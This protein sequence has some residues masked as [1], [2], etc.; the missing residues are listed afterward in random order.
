MLNEAIKANEGCRDGP[1]SCTG[2]SRV[3][4]A[5]RIKALQGGAKCLELHGTCF[6]TTL[7]AFSSANVRTRSGSLTARN[8]DPTCNGVHNHAVWRDP[9]NFGGGNV[10]LVF[11]SVLLLR[12]T[13]MLARLHFWRVNSSVSSS[14][15]LDENESEP[16]LCLFSPHRGT[17]LGD[18]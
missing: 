10:N 16:N 6:Q 17:P 3:T 4:H 1:P 13:G 11:F 12:L 18:L 5:T 15:K 7:T 8:P 9:I 14:V 2:A